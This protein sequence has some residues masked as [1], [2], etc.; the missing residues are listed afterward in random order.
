[1]G[2]NKLLLKNV[3]AYKRLQIIF[4]KG[5][6]TII[7]KSD[8][9]K[10]SI[11]RALRLVFQNRPLKNVLV[12]HDTKYANIIV[13]FDNDLSIGRKKGKKINQYQLNSDTLKAVGSEVPDK[14]KNILNMG[15][16]NIQS[17]SDVY[18]LLDKPSGQVAKSIN[19]ISDLSVMDRAMK[20]VKDDLRENNSNIE[21]VNTEIE[22]SITKIKSLEWIDGATEKI[23]ALL[24]K[25]KN[26][27]KIQ[28]RYNKLKE[29]IENIKYLKKK[30]E[31]LLPIE[32]EKE[33]KE[34]D[35]LLSSKKEIEQMM[36]SLKNITWKIKNI[37]ETL[38]NYSEINEEEFH[39]IE[40]YLANKDRI[41]KDLIKLTN[42]IQS[43][44]EKRKAIDKLELEITKVEEEIGSVEFCPSCG[45][46]L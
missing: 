11:I 41:Q 17:Q 9:G 29:L 13:N 35:D 42:Y 8:S 33:L 32:I 38:N 6:N 22:T 26:L 46:K 23:T 10:S 20:K 40:N 45:S 12:R 14:I 34:I 15:E 44:T 3:Q 5:V 27:R 37:E 28:K 36:F 16:E 31:I 4:D 24:H 7:G 2:I 25:E 1:M 18:F 39:E 43:I 19:E 30:I 21:R